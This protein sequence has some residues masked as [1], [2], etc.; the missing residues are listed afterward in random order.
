MKIII[1]GGEAAGM[2]AAAKAKRIDPTAEI[3][4]Y[5]ASE[6][7]SFGACGLPYYIGDEFSD[8]NFMAEF[9]PAQFAEKGITVL[10]HHRVI[11]LNTEQ[12]QLTVE[13][14]GE[15][16]TVNY[17]RLMIA[18]GAKEVLPPIKGLDKRGVYS[19][20]RMQD[21]LNIKTALADP[22]CHHVTIIGSGFIGL[23]VAEAMIHQGKTV[24]LIERAKCLIP[25]A[26]DAE[27]SQHIQPELERAGVQIHLQ[28]SVCEI[29][30]DGH[31]TSIKTD[32]EIYTTNMVICC[33]GVKPNTN[34]IA[35]TGIE[36]LANGAI[37][38]DQ[39]GKTSI[40]NIWAAGDCAT[41]WH[42]QL[43]QPAYIPLATGANKMGRLVGENI[44]GKNL[45]YDGTLGTSCVKILGLEAGRTGLSEREAQ[46]ANIDYRTV[47]IS[48]KCH[49]NYC[50]G[51]SPLYIKLIY[52]ADNKKLLGGQLI[53]NKGAVHRV[54]ALA[55]AISL[56]ATTEQLGMMDFAYAPPFART[57]DIMNVAGNVAK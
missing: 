4:V 27:I 34:F 37:I 50:E 44:A 12:Q 19:L 52:R 18:T 30:G 23:E 28:E 26:F 5:E 1:I 36:R 33:T 9:T 17:D 47:Y 21:G 16:H 32:K 39:Q 46:Q 42:A 29:I 51:Q 56:G 8:H 13:H 22:L 40:D 35:E 55:V 54:D 10:T 41:I 53:G 24:R 57:W 43:Q 15:T 31:V 45:S 14:Q 6:V 20:R 7:I 25:D 3:V 2:S 48:D 49:T 11:Q 38:I